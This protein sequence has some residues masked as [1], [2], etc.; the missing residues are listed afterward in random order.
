MNTGPVRLDRHARHILL[1]EIGGPGQAKL[2]RAHVAIVGAGGLG[3]PAALYLAAAGVGRLTLIDPDVVD[4]SNLQR[5]VLFRSADVGV[6]KVRASASTLKAL[7]P[8]IEIEPIVAA[9]HATNAENMIAGADIVLDGTDSFEAR[10]H[11]NQA[12]HN[13]GIPL[14]Q[15][16]GGMDKWVCLR[17]VAPNQG[18]EKHAC[19][20][21]VVGYLKFRHKRKP[22]RKWVLWV[23]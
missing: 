14:V 12:C 4:L 13:L 1:K 17:P 18:L 3:A 21:I 10:F 16:G 15:L 2:A 23:L 7:D 6:D 9:L 19:H 11:T 20:V 8:Q 5:Q 22:A